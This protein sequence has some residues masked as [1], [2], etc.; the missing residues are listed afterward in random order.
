MSKYRSFYAEI[1]SVKDLKE[2]KKKLVKYKTFFLEIILS[3]RTR[4]SEQPVT[5]PHSL[6]KQKAITKPKSKQP[7]TPRFKFKI[8]YN[9][10]KKPNFR[11]QTQYFKSCRGAICKT[12][13]VV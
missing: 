12:P 2:E 9:R 6:N 13:A 11:E 4:Y 1:A 10:S 5:S 7:S 8:L 3:K